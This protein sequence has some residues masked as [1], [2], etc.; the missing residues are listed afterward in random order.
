MMNVEM[1]SLRSRIVNI[2][3]MNLKMVKM[4]TV[5]KA[6]MKMKAKVRREMKIKQNKDQ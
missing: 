5:D 4:A 3:M 1:I 2:K 6:N